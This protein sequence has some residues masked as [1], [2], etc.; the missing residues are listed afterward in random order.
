MEMSLNHE[1]LKEIDRLAVRYRNDQVFMGLNKY[2]LK[3]IRLL[4]CEIRQQNI[5]LS[6]YLIELE[7]YAGYF[8][9]HYAVDDCLCFQLDRELFRK[10]R[11]SF[12]FLIRTRYRFRPRS[13]YRKYNHLGEHIT[14]STPSYSYLCGTQ[15]IQLDLFGISS[16][17]DL[18]HILCNSFSEFFGTLRRCVK[19]C[20]GALMQEEIIRKN[21]V[22]CRALYEQDY[23]EMLSQCRDIVKS[24]ETI[25]QL[26]TV[27]VLGSDKDEDV[28]RGF[29][30]LTRSQMLA[31]VLHNEV[32][33]LTECE[34]DE[35][36]QKL[37]AGQSVDFIKK[38]RYVITNLDKLSPKGRG[39]KMPS[40]TI[41]FLF[42][43]YQVESKNELAF[44]NY[45]KSK[46]SGNFEIPSYQAVN[47]A[48]CKCYRLNE[49]E[50][51]QKQEL[52]DKIDKLLVTYVSANKEKTS[53]IPISS[54]GVFV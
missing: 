11:S 39:N 37:F 3:Q 46:Y 25:L 26:G 50:I 15:P 14:Y 23:Q 43:R 5:C 7:E 8:L 20:Q 54:N 41:A 51:S 49:D 35:N 47:K 44:Y 34:L 2:N 45:L 12:S 22:L 42:A 18:I 36:E 4:V 6:K 16:F 17:P 28:L 52:N 1:K 40:L 30:K 27:D 32:R 24:Y 48:K 38:V 10:I 31:H 53:Q 13:P 33:K 29:H 21:S 9:S 19:L